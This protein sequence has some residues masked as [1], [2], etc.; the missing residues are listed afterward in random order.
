MNF[1]ELQLMKFITKKGDQ[2]L[3]EISNLD[4]SVHTK[5]H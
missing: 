2:H 3:Q 1:F 4:Q 5:L